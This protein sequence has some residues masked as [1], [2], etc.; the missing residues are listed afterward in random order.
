MPVEVTSRLTGEWMT[1]RRRFLSALFRGHVDKVPACTL[2]SVMTVELMDMVDA[3]F[4]E[5][6]LDAEMMAQADVITT[7]GANVH[8]KLPVTNT[9]GEPLFDAVRSLS[10]AASRW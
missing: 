9:R 8:V 3:P 2:S 7:W 1:P 5:A 10:R 6:H 4:P